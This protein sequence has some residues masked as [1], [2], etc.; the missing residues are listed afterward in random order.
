MSTTE[1]VVISS[2]RT[3][4]NFFC[5]CLGDF[6]EVL[7]LFEI[8]NA[9]GVMG[10]DSLNMLERLGEDLQIPTPERAT[11]RHL[12]EAVRSEPFRALGV[13]GDIAHDRGCTGLSYKVFPRQLS[14]DNLASLI[15]G[16]NRHVFLL[17][18][19]RLDVFISYEKARAKDVW[20]NESTKD[21]LPTV[22]VDDFLSWSEGVDQWYADMLHLARLHDKPYVIVDY[23]RDI[24]VPKSELMQR[25]AEMLAKLGTRV[26]VPEE[27]LRARFRK[28]DRAAEPFAKIDNGDEVRA[29]LEE[30]GRLDYALSSPLLEQELVA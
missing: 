18:R 28:Q 2:P 16:E 6:P 21:L 26:T 17:V 9:R 1:I 7:G 3:G 10:S 25:I 27:D 23:D 11:D 12:V 29:A 15:A 20:K 8:F 19:R 4:T 22:S 24:D 13:L 5:E 14:V 30:A